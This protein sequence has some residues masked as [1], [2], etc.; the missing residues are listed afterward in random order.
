M[1]FDALITLAVVT[2]VIGLLAFSRVAPDVVLLGGLTLLMV[3]PVAADG[4]WR[5]GVLSATEALSGLSNPGPVTVGVR[6]RCSASH[7]SPW[8]PTPSNSAVGG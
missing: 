4:G 3:F 6:R 5:L 8:G 2:I 1:P 7:P